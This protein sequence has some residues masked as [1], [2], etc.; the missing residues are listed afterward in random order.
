MSSGVQPKAHNPVELFI[1]ARW[2]I[3]AAFGRPGR[4]GKKKKCNRKDTVLVSTTTATKTKIHQN[5]L[6]AW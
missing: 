1:A 2:Q 4:K 6:Y 5:G 3:I